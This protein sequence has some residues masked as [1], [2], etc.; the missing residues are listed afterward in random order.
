MA[1]RDVPSAADLAGVSETA[2]MTLY[3]RGTE[4]GRPDALISD[5]LAARLLAGVD[6]PFA[7]RFGRPD[8]SHVLRAVQFDAEVRRFLRDRPG[9]TVVALGEGLETQFWRVDNGTVRWLTVDLPEIVEQRRRLLPAE[10]RNQLFAGSAFDPDW[11]PG[12]REVRVLD[13]PRGRGFGWG[14][15]Y[16]A[17]ARLPVL[18]GLLPMTVALR[19]QPKVH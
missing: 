4:A 13:V 10:E 5:P 2:L 6:Y 7:E 14:V 16:P 18:R 17:M 8:L 11:H 1:D 9:G 15:G 19:F 12:I 3:N